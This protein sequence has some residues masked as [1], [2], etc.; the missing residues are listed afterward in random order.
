VW[1]ILAG[2]A[3]A[4]P[5]ASG[6]VTA[7]TV[8]PDRAAVTREQA[9]QLAAGRNEVRFTDLPPGL[10]DGTLQ[11]EGAGGPGA[12][13][14][15][16]DVVTRNLADDRRARVAGLEARVRAAEAEVRAARDAAA[17]AA[18]EH[19]FLDSVRAEASK[20]V[21]RELLYAEQTPKHVAEL[22]ELLR[23]RIP[24][25]QARAQA[26]DQAAATADLRLS[27]LRRELDATR[28]DGQWQARDVVVQ[29]DA[30]AATPATVRLTYMV[31]GAGWTPMYDAHARVAA[32]AVDLTLSALVTQTTGEPWEDVALTLSTA[33]PAASTAPPQLAPFYLDGVT[34]GRGRAEA[35]R[36]DEE[37]AVPKAMSAGPPAE[38]M[39]V[40]TADV[41][42]EA[43]AVTFVVPGA[44]D[45]AGDGAERRVR[46]AEAHPKAT[47]T[48]VAVPRRDAAAYL[49]ARADWAESWPILPGRVST[50]AGDA[51]LGTQP[52]A[53]VGPGQPL[54]LGFGRDDRLKIAVDVVSDLTGRPQF[55]RVK[56]QRRWVFRAV[57][58]AAAPVRVELRDQLPIPRRSKYAVRYRGDAPTS[59]D[60]DQRYTFASELAAGATAEVRFGY[61]V[62][63]PE[64]APPAE[65]P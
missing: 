18:A 28:G 57:N 55:G 51:Y 53:P 40:R 24:E 38:P 54:E 45:I 63:F 47:F 49:V 29:L 41:R 15:G 44:S 59:V 31:P 12:S 17:A 58:G 21:A 39:R 30:A 13:L 43:T 20:Q 32:G 11:A 35:E 64:N 19:G 26:A 62:S 60:A 25:V 6:R 5:G 9:V 7:V 33:R 27:A 3:W 16:L 14:V 50:F 34:Y 48:D 4:D 56:Q 1:C 22:A 10:L 65:L 2:A 61:D 46:V 42:A 37:F 52:L 23:A 8:F 36:E